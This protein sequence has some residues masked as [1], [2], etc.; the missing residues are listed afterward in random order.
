MVIPY[1]HKANYSFIEEVKSIRKQTIR[2]ESLRLLYVAMT[3]AENELYVFGTED[4]KLGCW[5]SDLKKEFPEHLLKAAALNKTPSKQ[6]QR[7]KKK[8]IPEYFYHKHITNNTGLKKSQASSQ[9]LS[10]A[11]C[12][13]KKG[14]SK[15]NDL[16]STL[17]HLISLVVL[18]L[19]PLLKLLL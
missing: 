4:C 3:R 14:G 16:I 15:F 7:K 13:A 11:Y 8:T 1:N 12:L 6:L 10:A 18:T 9:A 19:I 2:N 5:F 17:F